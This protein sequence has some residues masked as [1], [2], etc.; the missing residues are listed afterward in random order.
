MT[1]QDAS[2]S[3][4]T[5]TRCDTVELEFCDSVAAGEFHVTLSHMLEQVQIRTL[6]APSR[7]ERHVWGPMPLKTPLSVGPL[8]FPTTATATVVCAAD[9]RVTGTPSTAVPRQQYRLILLRA[10]RA[11]SVTTALPPPF[12]ATAAADAHES[13]RS[14]PLAWIVEAAVEKVRVWRRS[15]VL[16]E[17]EPVIACARE[18][19]KDGQP[20][21]RTTDSVESGMARLTLG[22]SR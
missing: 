11:A 7:G 4:S 18:A 14:Q 2:D 1:Q 10:D 8:V 6:Q 15:G 13:S 3:N 22:G 21:R 17:L 9:E 16:R 20:G 19:L 12:P 5:R